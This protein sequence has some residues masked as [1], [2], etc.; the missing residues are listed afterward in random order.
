MTTTPSTDSTSRVK[1]DF[2]RTVGDVEV[3]LPSLSYLK[4]GLI[5]RIRRMHDIDA[6][7]TLIELTVSAEALVALDN[8]NQDEYQ[9]LLDEWRIH[10]GVGL[11]ES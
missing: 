5:R 11:G 3:R 4:P 2:V 8:M 1:D 10:S 6:M 7:Y 9:A